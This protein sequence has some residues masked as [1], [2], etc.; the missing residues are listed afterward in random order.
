[1]TRRGASGSST[2]KTAHGL[3][4]RPCSPSSSTVSRQW[5]YAFRVKIWRVRFFVSFSPG[6]LLNSIQHAQSMS[7]ITKSGR[8][9]SCSCQLPFFSNNGD[10]ENRCIFVGSCRL[11]SYYLVLHGCLLSYSCFVT[12][13]LVQ[14]VCLICKYKR[15]PY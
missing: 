1:M 2:R 10:F 8:L 13:M 7:K 4:H 11:G 9:Q 3:L 5:K 15:M 12:H 14:F 6:T